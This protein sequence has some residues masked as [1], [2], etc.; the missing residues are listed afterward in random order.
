MHLAFVYVF[1]SF[2]CKVHTVSIPNIEN[3]FLEPIG[4]SKPNTTILFNTTCQQ[5]LCFYFDGSRNNTYL[6]LN[7]FSNDTCQYF[8]TFP[9]S[10]KLTSSLGAKLYFLQNIF[11][12]IS[13]CC[14]QN[15]TDVLSRL[16][17][18]TP[19]KIN[20]T[21]TPYAFGYDVNQPNVAV[22]IGSTVGHL[23][24]F[25]PFNLAF[26]RNDSIW[27]S[28]TVALYNS[29]LFTSLN[30]IAMVYVLNSQ[31]MTQITNITYPNLSG[32]RKYIFLNDGKT[33]I[34]NAQTNWSLTV[35]NATSPTN[36]IFQVNE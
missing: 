18:V 28:T 22:V 10:Y 3:V 21:F 8:N 26:I 23:Y 31:T 29:S 2:V 6:A 35:F 30:G 27:T 17:S 7:C 25:N 33:M 4:F 14:R 34:A 5:C 12:N 9:T 11:P 1:L 15:I 13:T 19:K 24:W 20:L 16:Q 32:T 36:Y